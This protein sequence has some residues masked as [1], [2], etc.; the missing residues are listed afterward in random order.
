MSGGAAIAVVGFA[1]RFPEAPTPDAFWRLLREGREAIT[2]APAD[3]LDLDGLSQSMPGLRRSRFIDHIDEFDSEFFGISPNEAAAMDPQQQLIL[4][5]SW[6]ALEDTAILPD[7]VK[8]SR[9]G[10]FIGAISSDYSDLL[11]WR[12]GATFSRHALTGSNRGMI[13]N[14]VSYILG[15]RGPSMTVDAASPRPWSRST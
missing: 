6:E 1:C 12:G 13:A 3:R 7:D 4:E 8:G 14:R 10:T 9:T 15:L 11:R 2:D 5:L